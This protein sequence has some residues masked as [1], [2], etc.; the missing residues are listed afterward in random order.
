MFSY[1]AHNLAGSVSSTR[2]YGCW[3]VPQIDLILGFGICLTG[4][5]YQAFLLHMA[6]DFAS[7]PTHVQLITS[8]LRDIRATFRHH[9]HY[10]GLN[11]RQWFGFWPAEQWAVME[12]SKFIFTVH[13][14]YIGIPC[15]FMGYQ[16]TPLTSSGTNLASLI[17]MPNGTILTMQWQLIELSLRTVQIYCQYII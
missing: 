15:A 4:Q 12:R 9:A 14:N 5:S 10:Y 8:Q 6:N 11:F 7:W 1:S 17:F 2:L 16:H 3:F 13:T